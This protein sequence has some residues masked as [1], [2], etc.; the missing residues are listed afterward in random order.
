MLCESIEDIL[1]ELPARF[2]Q[3]PAP[4][5]GVKISAL[6][7]DQSPE[8]CVLALIGSDPV[9]VD[10]LVEMTGWP[11]D[12]VM[13]VLAGLELRRLIRSRDGCYSLA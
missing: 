2:R 1:A 11:V 13:A 4:K 6:P 9:E 3:E 8:A 10:S 5:T 12:Q 7:G